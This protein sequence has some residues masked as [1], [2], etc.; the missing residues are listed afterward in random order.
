MPSSLRADSESQSSAPE[1]APAPTPE[2]ARRGWLRGLTIKLSGEK[3]VEPQIVHLD[4]NAL[5][6]FS[7]ESGPKN[8]TAGQPADVHEFVPSPPVVPG[9]AER[10]ADAPSRSVGPGLSPN[11]A[12]AAVR[13]VSSNLRLMALATALMLT[14]AAVALLMFRISPEQSLAALQTRTGNLTIQTRP[15]GSEVLVDG[16]RRGVTPLSLTLAPGAHTLTVQNGTDKR[17][18]PLTIAAGSDVT[19]S[20]DMKTAAPVALF[21][22]VSVATDPP[23]A[24]VT[25][26]G[27]SRG[28]SPIVV[29]DLTAEQHTVA[30]AGDTG[31][32]DRKVTVTAGETAAV[33]FSLPKASGPVGGWLALSTPF[34]VEVTESNAVVG[35]LGTTRIMLAAGRHDV[36]LTNRS[37]G[38]QDSRHVEITGGKTTTMRVE[39]PRVSVSVNARPWADVAVDGSNVGQTPLANLQVAI[40]SHEFAFLHPQLGER[41]QTFVVTA[42]GTNR[43]AVDLTK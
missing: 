23:G 7:S 22:K 40:G 28:V 8:E 35:A 6:A 15:D 27:H 37:V 25:V 4:T 38:Y 43:I 41:R 24:R 29:G 34:D 11:V 19:Q 39:A 5:L 42:K 33:M 1:A 21:G 30:V 9:A 13:S 26:D 32:A 10:A 14:A 36:V 17:V 12:R 31:S 20:L 2:P 3:P 16:E 18:V